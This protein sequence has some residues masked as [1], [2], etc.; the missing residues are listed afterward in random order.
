MRILISESQLVLDVRLTP[1]HWR[2]MIRP[3]PSLL[4]PSTPNPG[5]HYAYP[6][7]PADPLRLD[8]DVV[9][10]GATPSGIAAAIQVSRMGRSVLLLAFGR[11]IGGMTTS[12]LGATDVGHQGAI[13]GIS[14]E[15]YERVGLHYGQSVS[16]RFEPS[17]AERVL[18]EMLDDAGVRVL[19]E[20]RLIRVQSE[21]KRLVA[22]ETEGGHRVTGRVFID[23]GYEGDLM[24]AAGV[25]YTVG[26][27]PNSRYRETLNG[28]HF[29]HP[30]HNFKAWVDPYRTPRDPDSG[31]LPGVTAEVPGVNGD[32]DEAIQAY[33]FRVC[34]TNQPS[35]QRP[36]PRPRGYD[37]A[38]HELLLRYIEAGVWDALYLTLPVPHHKTD[39][40][41]FGAVSSDHIGAN[42]RWPDGS[43]AER[44]RIFQEHVAY[45]QGLYYFLANDPRVPASIRDELA[46]WGLPLDE[47]EETGGWPHELYIRESRRMLAD[48]VMTEHHCRKFD[49]SEDS[50]GLAAYT[51]DSHN[52]RRLV[53]D[54]RVYNEGNVEVPPSSPYEI[55]YRA[56]VPPRGH[57][58]NLLVPWCLSASHIAFGSIRM[59]P[60]GM[61]LGQSAGAAACLSIE[62]GVDIQAVPYDELADCLTSNHQVLTWSQEPVSTGI[63]QW[64]EQ[65]ADRTSV[66]TDNHSDHSAAATR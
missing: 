55:S 12:G 6:L 5:L 20:Q 30:G 39:T 1:V 40:N 52:C 22:L 45:N 9:I 26:R 11:R 66:M 4:R 18:S 65:P 50:I 47:F 2:V 37:P 53:I 46:A 58:A 51:M 41:N 21:A 35:N 7:Q 61:V 34:L 63:N 57:C 32:G 54:G 64:V 3:T 59:E 27:E 10:Y 28:V 44:E 29:G 60:V 43:Y 17:V 62:L 42:H 8:A 13:G 25:P 33:N 15:F 24:A 16:W 48:V 56:I 19:F 31:L 23:A 36:F 49:R 14:R 38:R